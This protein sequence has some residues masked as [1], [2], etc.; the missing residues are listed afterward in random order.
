MSGSTSGSMSGSM[1][2]G[3][4]GRSKDTSSSKIGNN[5]RPFNDDASPFNSFSQTKPPPSSSSS[6][7]SYLPFSSSAAVVGMNKQQSSPLSSSSPFTINEEEGKGDKLKKLKVKIQKEEEIQINDALK[8]VQQKLDIN[9]NSSLLSMNE[10]EVLS[11]SRTNNQSILLYYNKFLI[12]YDECQFLKDS[13]LSCQYHLSQPPPPS[14]SSSFQLRL[15]NIET[16]FAYLENLLFPSNES[17]MMIV[18]INLVVKEQSRLSS[19]MYDRFE[20][21]LLEIE[22]LKKDL[23]SHRQNNIMIVADDVA[24]RHVGVVA[25]ELSTQ[26]KTTSILKNLKSRS[27]NKSPITPSSLSLS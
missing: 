20:A 10:E 17:S 14:S 12:L 5:K 19:K 24:S 23:I 16:K 7:S 2:G 11:S 9:F 13:L 15:T 8:I 22:T 21:L 26:K 6:S 4:S 1:S 25:N 18:N 27:M 3:M